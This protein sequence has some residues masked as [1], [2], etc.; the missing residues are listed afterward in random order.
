LCV[1]LSKK[2]PHSCFAK[3]VNLSVATFLRSKPTRTRVVAVA[4]YLALFAWSLKR[5]GLP[6]DRIAVTGWV[7]VA[8]IF[9]NAGKT[10]KDQIAMIRDWSIFAGI[11]FAYEY[12]R[13]LSDQLGRPIS[14]L[15]VRNI[16]RALFFGTDPNVWMQQHLNVSKVLSWYEYPPCSHVYD[17]LHFSTWSRGAVVVDQSRHVGALHAQTWNL[18]LLG[19]CNICS[20]PS[21][22]TLARSKTGLHCTDTSHHR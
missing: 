1:E 21:C 16:D 17:A 15:A 12:S 14:Y 18:V 4:L 3:L 2:L 6:V 10:M 19:M 5:F 7:L 22:T 8:F 13:G 9:A 11:L 20:I